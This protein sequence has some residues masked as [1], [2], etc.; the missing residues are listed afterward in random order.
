LQLRK[1]LIAWPHALSQAAAAAGKRRDEDVRRQQAAIA[2]QREM[3]RMRL[4]EQ[5]KKIE[6]VRRDQ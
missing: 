5:R 6:A 4:E 3:E 1:L 2:A